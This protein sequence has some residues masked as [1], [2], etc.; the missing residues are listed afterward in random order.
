VRTVDVEKKGIQS[1]QADIRGVHV[2]ACNKPPTAADK[3]VKNDEAFW[4]RWEYVL[5][6]NKFAMDPE[7]KNRNF[8]DANFSGYLNKVI[9]TA[10]KIGKENKLLK[11]SSYS[12][13]RQIWIKCAEP[14]YVFITEN[15]NKIQ[16]WIINFKS[17][18]MIDAN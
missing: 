2:Y 4:N 17:S 3:D 16:A 7:F 6:S 9:E 14:V 13:V 15:M 11:V 10:L 1:F 8:T 5:F 12:E 18:D